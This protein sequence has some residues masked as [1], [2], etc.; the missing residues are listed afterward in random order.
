MKNEAIS[1]GKKRM[2]M[3]KMSPSENGESY[4]E[5]TPQE[6]AQETP[7]EEEQEQAVG[8]GDV[9]QEAQAL[10]DSIGDNHELCEAV[11]EILKEKYE[12]QKNQDM[13]DKANDKT[14]YSMSDE[15]MPK[16]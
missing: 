10:V 3:V 13:Q 6:E 1:E 16:D 12:D 7:G 11:Y 2:G 8:Q 9:Q 4:Q 15:D 5:G 14:D